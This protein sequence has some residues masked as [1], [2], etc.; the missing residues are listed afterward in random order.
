[1]NF[2]SGSLGHTPP[3]A[4]WLDVV[5]D[6]ADVVVPVGSGVLVPEADDVAQLMHH[7]AELVAVLPDGDSL[8]SPTPPAYVRAA[9]AGG[10]ERR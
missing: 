10:G 4:T 5:P 7:D 2:R 6:D 8:G 9:P 3:R 1:M